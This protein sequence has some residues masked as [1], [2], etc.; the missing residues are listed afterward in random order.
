MSA[1][2]I[3]GTDPRRQ[4]FAAVIAILAALASSGTLATNI[5]L[6]SL[7]SIASSLAV[8]TPEVTATITVFLAVFA[9]GQLFVGP[10]AD[11]YGRR[12][13][14]VTGFIIFMLGSALCAAAPD[15]LTMLTGRAIQAI[16]A[17]ATS[18]LSRAIARDLFE[19][20]ALARALTLIMIAMATAPGFS[21]LLGGALE[22][23][24]GWRA[25][26]I[27]VGLFGVVALAAYVSLL[28]ETHRGEPSPL[29]LASVTRSYINLGSDRRLM[30]PMIT[31]SLIMGGLFA[32]FSASPRILIEGLGFTPI[33]L[34]LFFAGTVLI[35]FA[36]GLLSARLAKKLGLERTIMLGL[37][38]ATFGSLGLLLAG[39]AHAGFLPFLAGISLFLLGMGAVN[40]LATA[41]ALS[42][43][44]ANAGAAS[45]LLGFAQ[46]AGA[47]VAVF[48]TA[49]LPGG[50]MAALGLVLTCG[51]L[52]A[53]AIYSRRSKSAIPAAA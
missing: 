12:I 52:L 22:Q 51:S 50:A 27:F 39:N 37:L 33:A 31:V 18:V 19:G 23:L 24:F 32:M 47:A 45:A 41:Q 16:G 4:P 9:V 25:G 20:P 35:V 46:M 15:L 48:A 14:V 49:N 43:F 34:G 53:M 38:F 29:N 42:P 28:G 17:C 8:S 10:I 5:L 44:G 2:A 30:V 21:P 7:P 1:P 36:S 11:R 3:S 13:P 26:F 40:P 6:P